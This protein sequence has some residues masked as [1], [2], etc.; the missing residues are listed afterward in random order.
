ME[1][2]T[3]GLNGSFDASEIKINISF[4]KPKVKFCLSLRYNSDKSYLFVNGKKNSKFKT[5]NKIVNFSSH[6]FLKILPNKFD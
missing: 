3:F 2:G 1:G 5:C 4:S 6:F